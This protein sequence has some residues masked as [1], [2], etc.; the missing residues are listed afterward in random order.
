LASIAQNPKQ[1]LPLQLDTK[2]TAGL[3][4]QFGDFLLVYPSRQL[5]AT[6]LFP[7]GIGMSD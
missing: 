2:K 7:T 1:A 5:V 4:S 3:V 6:G